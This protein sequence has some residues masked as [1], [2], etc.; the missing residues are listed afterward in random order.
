[1]KESE[2]IVA[3]DN[4]LTDFDMDA[5]QRILFWAANK[6]CIHER[7]SWEALSQKL[8]DLSARYDHA[9]ETAEQHVLDLEKAENKPKKG[10][11][12]RIIVCRECGEPATRIEPS[13]PVAFLPSGVTPER[14]IT[15]RCEPCK[16]TWMGPERSAV[17]PYTRWLWE[18][19]SSMATKR[20]P[21]KGKKHV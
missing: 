7:S 17:G 16:F 10:K 19:E 21:K 18:E 20:K 13:T 14:G 2:A 1:M 15:F 6:H 9:I 3:I 4:I 12:H 5:K 11:R 8:K